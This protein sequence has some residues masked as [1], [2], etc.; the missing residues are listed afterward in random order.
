[1]A[2][3]DNGNPLNWHTHVFAVDYCGASSMSG[4]KVVN[5]LAIGTFA[6]VDFKRR[7]GVSAPYSINQG[8]IIFISGEISRSGFRIESERNDF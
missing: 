1:M 6:F 5:L 2:N 7:I 4:N 3:D 8:L